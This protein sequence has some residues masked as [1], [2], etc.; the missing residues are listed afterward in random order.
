M[1]SWGSN[2]SGRRAVSS[3]SRSV[4]PA[5]VKA[6]PLGHPR[7]HARKSS[8]SPRHPKTWK[9]PGPQQLPWCLD[10]K[11]Q[12]RRLPG[13]LPRDPARS[14]PRLLDIVLILHRAWPLSRY[15]SRRSPV[16]PGRVPNLHSSG[17]S[18]RCFR[19]AAPIPVQRPLCLPRRWC[20]RL[21]HQSLPQPL[22]TWACGRR[23]CRGRH[24][25]RRGRRIPSKYVQGEACAEESSWQKTTLC[26]RRWPYRSCRPLQTASSSRMAKPCWRS[27]ASPR[28]MH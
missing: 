26:C 8:S 14:P 1:A 22:P 19:R 20:P 10:P 13:R 12:G 21:R 6:T 18:E 27:W 16:G 3:G 9:H 15:L 17:C 5:A 24:R 28:R 11:A 2:Q 7:S 23:P 25:N 4:P